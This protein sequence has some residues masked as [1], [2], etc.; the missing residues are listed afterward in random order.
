[1]GEALSITDPLVF[2]ENW[3]AAPGAGASHCSRLRPSSGS[4]LARFLLAIPT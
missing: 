4:S 3:P 2:P 1:L